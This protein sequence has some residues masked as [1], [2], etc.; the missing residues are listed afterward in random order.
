MVVPEKPLFA[1]LIKLPAFDEKWEF[2]ILF[3]TSHHSTLAEERS[4][5]KNS[6]ALYFQDVF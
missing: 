4:I 6:S 3:R 5:Q 1:L 2:I